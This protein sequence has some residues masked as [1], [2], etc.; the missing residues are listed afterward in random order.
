MPEHRIA[1]DPR[2]PGL[3]YA[4]CGLFEIAELLAPGGRAWFEDNGRVFCLNSEAEV[5]PPV[6]QIEPVHAESEDRYSRTFE[7]LSLRFGEQRLRLNWWLNATETDKSSLKTWGG[8]QTP[9]RVLEGTLELLEPCGAVEEL[10]TA[11]TFTTTR[12]GVDAR[13]AWEP[14]DLG[15]SPN[16]TTRKEALT[17][18]WVELLAVVGLQGFRPAGR[19]RELAYSAWLE[20][21]SLQP[22]RAACAAQWDGLLVKS[23]AFKVVTRGQG[24]KTFAFA[25]G[26][27]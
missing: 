6:P 13:S 11:S 25:A 23:F 10:F 21:L 18:P 20:A 26:G 12:F 16:D 7:P 2:N 24:Y 1:I 15:Y 4:C 27:D 8:Q 22:A 9:R 14:L 5:P 3:F 17:Y 19:R